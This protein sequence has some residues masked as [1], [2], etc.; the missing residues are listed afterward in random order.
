MAASAAKW[1]LYRERKADGESPVGRSQPSPWLLC[2]HVWGR[3][4]RKMSIRP[5]SP[6]PAWGD[7]GP[8]L[9]TLSEGNA[10]VCA[11]STALRPAGG[12]RETPKFVLREKNNK[13][14]AD[15][16][17]QARS[18]L[19]METPAGGHALPGEFHWQPR[20][21]VP[22]DCPALPRAH[23]DPHMHPAPM[24]DPGDV[25]RVQMQKRLWSQAHVPQ[26]PLGP[27]RIASC[28]CGHSWT[29]SPARSRTRSQSP[30]PKWAQLR[31]G[32]RLGKGSR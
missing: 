19:N 4:D 15:E 11:S 9:S 5:S 29:H 20:L 16:K 22:S 21:R 3:V 10:G 12:Q 31:S 27:T 32:S 23:T 30:A 2:L 17:G 25:T 28:T 1:W 6:T 24:V 14:Q 26:P 13:D 7:G 18:R 8:G